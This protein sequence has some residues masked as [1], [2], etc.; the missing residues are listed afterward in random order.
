[1]VRR[2]PRRGRETRSQPM[3]VR[4]VDDI[5]L[6]DPSFAPRPA[7]SR[8]ERRSPLFRRQAEAERGHGFQSGKLRAA[9][10]PDIAANRNETERHTTFDLFKSVPCNDRRRVYGR[11][12]GRS[13]QILPNSVASMNYFYC[14]EAGDFA[15]KT[16]LLSN[17]GTN[18]RL[19]RNEVEWA[20]GIPPRCHRHPRASRR[21]WRRS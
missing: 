20:V 8:Q 6:A 21:R 11:S 13:M 17:A 7:R 4:P 5:D 16:R 12:P 3:A 10:P 14:L 9:L 15:G 2:G 18:A 1:M 19:S